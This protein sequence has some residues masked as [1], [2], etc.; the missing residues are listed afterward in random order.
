[1]TTNVKNVEGWSYTDQLHQTIGGLPDKH[2][3]FLL[4]LSLPL[5]SAK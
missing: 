3:L 4:T 2:V 5:T 1:M